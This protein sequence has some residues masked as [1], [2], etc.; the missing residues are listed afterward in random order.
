[1]AGHVIN[2]ASIFVRCYRTAITGPLPAGRCL[3]DSNLSEIQPDLVEAKW[4]R[5]GARL[6]A[7]VFTMNNPLVT[8]LFYNLVK[9]AHTFHI[10]SA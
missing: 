7:A 6:P 8:F 2:T 10:V 4:R 3:C 9:L 1:M 5:D